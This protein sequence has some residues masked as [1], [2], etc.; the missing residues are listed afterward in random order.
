MRISEHRDYEFTVEAADE[1]DA[2][3]SGWDQF[4]DSRCVDSESEITVS[5]A[6]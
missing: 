2:R 1:D 6:A 3:D 4:D 5:L